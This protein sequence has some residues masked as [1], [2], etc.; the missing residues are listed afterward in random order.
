LLEGNVEVLLVADAGSPTDRYRT[1][2]YGGW[3]LHLRRLLDRIDPDRDNEVAAHAILALLAPDL[4]E[5]LRHEADY[6]K[7]RLVTAL[8]TSAARI[9]RPSAGGGVSRDARPS[10]ADVWRPGAQDFV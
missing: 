4:F 9:A 1:G 10:T 6:S 2:A 3:V 5:H 7:R 8:T